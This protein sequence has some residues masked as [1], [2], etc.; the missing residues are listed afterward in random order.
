MRKPNLIKLTRLA[1]S[2]P[3]SPWSG[4]LKQLYEQNCGTW[5]STK[6]CLW[7]C[8]SAN[9]SKPHS[10]RLLANRLQR[11]KFLKLIIHIRNTSIWLLLLQIQRCAM[12]VLCLPK[13]DK[14]A[15]L[16]TIVVWDGTSLGFDL[17]WNLLHP[18]TLIFLPGLVLFTMGDFWKK[19][20]KYDLI[21]S[22]VL[23]INPFVGLPKFKQWTTHTADGTYATLG[24][25][26]SKSTAD[27]LRSR[28]SSSA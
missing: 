8:H 9:S 24:Q 12:L 13:T 20:C 15:L 21:L 17:I 2:P 27:L 26:E 1:P 23:C 14:P 6:V 18:F 16:L 4:K 3:I 10:K 19:L 7:F 25:S 11:T 22:K 28:L 5:Y